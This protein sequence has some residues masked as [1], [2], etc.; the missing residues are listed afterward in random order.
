MLDHRKAMA[1]IE[2]RRETAKALMAAPEEARRSQLAQELLDAYRENG[3]LER[4]A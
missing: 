4:W 2:A 3:S 1:E